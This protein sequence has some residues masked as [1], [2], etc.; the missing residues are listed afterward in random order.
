MTRLGGWPEEGYL[1]LAQQKWWRNRILTFRP[2]EVHF[3]LPFIGHDESHAV[4]DREWLESPAPVDFHRIRI[5]PKEKGLL[6]ADWRNRF[7][8]DFQL[9][10]AATI[11]E[12][13]K[14]RSSKGS[15]P[16]DVDLTLEIVQKQVGIYWELAAF[17]HR[18]GLRVIVR[19]SFQ[20]AP[21]RFPEAPDTSTGPFG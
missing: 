6:G 17:F 16:V 15:Y 13:R 21:R 12:N 18:S 1:D 5:P 8:F 2:R 3:G 14:E 11:F 7:V 9:P 20:G 4:F 19:E 10:P